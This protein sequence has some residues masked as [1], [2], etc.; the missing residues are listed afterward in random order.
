MSA[1]ADVRAVL[2]EK[3]LVQRLSSGTR[4][5]VRALLRNKAGFLGFLGVMFFIILTTLGPL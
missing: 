2:S 5:T 1:S 3:S 4:G